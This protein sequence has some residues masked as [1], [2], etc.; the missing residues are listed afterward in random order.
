MIGPDAGGVTHDQTGVVTASAAAE[1]LSFAAAPTFTI[2]ALLT[3]V[4]DNSPP[5]AFCAAA[6]SFWPAGM[7]P[8]YLLMA[9]FH[10]V[11]WLRLISGRRNAA[12]HAR[13]DTF[14]PDLDRSSYVQTVE[15]RR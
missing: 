9:G 8:M 2:M 12:R 15:P 1:F 10:L 4:L 7:A 3:F 13:Q 5:N 6:D 14:F 11:Q